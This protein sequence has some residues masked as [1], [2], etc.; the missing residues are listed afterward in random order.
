[1]VDSNSLRK[2]ELYNFH[3]INSLYECAAHLSELQENLIR[4]HSAGVGPPLSPMRTRMVLALRINVLAK[5]CRYA[6]HTLQSSQLKQAIIYSRK[7]SLGENF[8]S[9]HWL[10]CY[11]GARRPNAWLLHESS[12]ASTNVFHKNKNVKLLDGNLW[13]FTCPPMFH[14]L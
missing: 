10:T 6:W 2:T 12:V 13:N 14:A 11:P 4:S 9:F 7:S 5:G 1:M 8:H 3:T